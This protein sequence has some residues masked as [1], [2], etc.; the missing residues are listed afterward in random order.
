MRSPKGE[1]PE[2]GEPM[3]RTPEA[4]PRRMKWTFRVL[5]SMLLV[6]AMALALNAIYRH[7]NA[8]VALVMLAAALIAPGAWRLLRTRQ[9]G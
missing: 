2:G 4:N 3:D 8:T 5:G 6:L 9:Q 1:P 7:G